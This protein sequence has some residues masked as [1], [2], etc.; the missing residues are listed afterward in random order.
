MKITIPRLRPKP[1]KDGTVNYFWEPSRSMRQHGW[2]SRALGKDFE[3]ACAEAKR[4]NEK[5]DAWQEG[6]LT[7]PQVRAA[8]RRHTLRDVWNHFVDAGYPSV[9]SP[10]TFL[11]PNTIEAYKYSWSYIEA[12]AGDVAIS[13]IDNRQVKKLVALL[14]TPDKNGVVRHTRAFNTVKDLRTLFTYAQEVLGWIDRNPAAKARISKPRPRRTLI[15]HAAHDAL[16]NEFDALGEKG[17]ALACMIAEKLG[18]RPGDVRRM[19]LSKWRII[20]RY[21]LTDVSDADYA[22]LCEGHEDVRGFEIRQEKTEAWVC[23]PV[24]GEARIRIEM[25]AQEARQAGSTLLIR[26]WRTGLMYDRWRFQELFRT[27][28]IA[29]AQ[30]AIRSGDSDLATDLTGIQ[31]RD[32]RRSAVVHLHRLGV[33]VPGISATTG[34][35]LDDV[36]DILKT[37]MPTTIPAAARSRITALKNHAELTADAARRTAALTAKKE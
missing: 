25:A 30:R 35:S 15:S 4:L 28:R 1:N 18:Q 36:T 6:N 32:Y 27:T 3:G 13:A 12:W 9:R 17:M 14:L 31:Y 23:I 16:V 19:S 22:I 29:A 2:Q 26:D 11:K 37:Y 5:V 33:N 8:A 10:G 21:E 24:D 7:L 34:H 20:H